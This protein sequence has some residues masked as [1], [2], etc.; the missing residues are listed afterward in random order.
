[1]RAFALAATLA[2]AFAWGQGAMDQCAGKDD[3]TACKTPSGEAGKCTWLTARERDR[4]KIRTKTDC[5]VEGRHAGSCHTCA[6][7]ANMKEIAA[8]AKV[9]DPGGK[10]EY[11]EPKTKY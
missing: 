11:N 8:A 9:N 7:D 6:T 5:R 3:D 2:A 4:L 1:M 10:P